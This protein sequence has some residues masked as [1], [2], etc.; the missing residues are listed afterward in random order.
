MDRH[1]KLEITSKDVIHSFWVPQIEPEAGCRPGRAQQDRRSRRPHRDVPRD[2]HRALRPRPLADAQP[3]DR[4]AAGADATVAEV[5]RGAAAR[6]T[7]RP[8]AAPRGLHG[9]RLRRAA[10]RS[11]GRRDRKIGPDL[12]NLKRRRPRRTGEPLEA[13]IKQSIVDPGRVHRARLPAGRDAAR[14]SARRSRPTKLDQ[15]VQYLA[16]EREL[17]MT[18]HADTH[19]THDAPRAAAAADR[20]PPLDGA[21]LAARPVGDAAL[22]FARRSASSA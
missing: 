9:E 21:R 13:Y 17:T 11:A 4:D 19:D 12:D 15:L 20:L 16:A 22:G 18:A 2:L 1:V 14:R 7:S 3:G 5:A 6:P 10:T 8:A